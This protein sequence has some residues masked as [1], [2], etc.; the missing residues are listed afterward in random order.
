MK[1][2]K[3]PQFT[4][5]YTVFAEI[6]TQPWWLFFNAGCFGWNLAEIRKIGN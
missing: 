6:S 2:N 3:N 5:I 1:Q 4:G